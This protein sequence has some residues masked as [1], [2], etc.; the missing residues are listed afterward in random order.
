[1]ASTPS[2]VPPAASAATL[3]QIDELPGPRGWP[4]LGVAP[5]LGMRRI[6][7]QME[8]WSRRYG[9][10]FRCQLGRTRLLVVS[11]HEAIAAILRDRPDGF[12]RGER[13]AEVVLEMGGTAGLFIAE[14]EAWRNQR[15]MVMASFAPAHVRAYFPALRRVTERLQARWNKAA[16]AGEVIDPQA[17]FKRF[18]VDAIAG[19]AFGSEVNTL[20]SGED[21]IQQHLDVVLAGTFRRAMAPLSYWRWF[22]LPADRRLERSNLAL[23]AAIDDFVAQARARMAAKPELREH[24]RNLLEAMIA[25]ADRGDAGVDNNDVVANV[26]TML[27]AGEDTTAN[28]LAWL[29]YLL[30]RNPQALRQARDEVD[31]LAPDIAT[32]SLEQIDSLAYLEA[33]ANEAMR[34]RP[35]APFMG[36]QALRDTTVADI[37][38]PAGTMLWCVL[39]HN[40][41]DAAHFPDPQQFDPQRWLGQGAATAPSASSRRA[42]MP[43]GSGP[44]LCPGR[45]LAL[46]EIKLAMAML[47]RQFDIR[48]LEAPGE[49]EAQEIMA[50]T[51]NPVGLRMRLAPRA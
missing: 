2:L 33:C 43:F 37:H 28:T 4:L 13:L 7:Q 48:S 15:R 34:L 23:R 27:L 5:R 45:Y 9:P 20:E 51:M 39:R 46:I 21:V 16:A 50:F 35:V 8:A 36:L 47:L 24:P 41:V 30:Y 42:A 17:D 19:L 12:S 26:S 18:T 14:G 38:V 1:M 32:A 49:D 29:S 31:R 6:H 10:F 11:D 40:T 25:A 44:R 3:R 22:K